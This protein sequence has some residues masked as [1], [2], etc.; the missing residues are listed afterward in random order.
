MNVMTIQEIIESALAKGQSALSEYQ[1][2][3]VLKSRGIPVSE[4]ALVHNADEAVQ[5][6]HRIGYPVALKACAW[7][8]MH[9][10]EKGWMALNLQGD[11]A[12][13][14]A[15][16]RIV[17]MADLKLEGVLV[18]EMVPGQRELVVGLSRDPSFGPCVMLGFGGIMTEV[19][20]DTV[21]RMAPIDDIEARDMA[22]ALR[23]KDLLGPF[24]GQAPARMDTL[25]RTLVAI[26]QIG[27]EI[28]AISEIDI[29][30]LIILPDGRL[31]AVDALIVLERNRHAQI[32]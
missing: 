8:L 25:C 32:D 18:Q 11:D 15:F 19:I 9:K 26:G 28:D 12:V 13:R 3:A 29:N 17:G 20:Q 22:E 27:L 16:N 30:P 23:T 21:F 14:E 24:R 31:K 7:K 1:S 10:S 2:K 4:E 6:A 5:A